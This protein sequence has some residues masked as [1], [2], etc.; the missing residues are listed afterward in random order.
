MIIYKRTFSI[1]KGKDGEAH[2][3]LVEVVD[4]INV[5]YPGHDA[6]V[7]VNVHGPVNQLHF[8]ESFASLAEMEAVFRQADDDPA[9]LALAARG[10][11][12]LESDEVTIYR[13]VSR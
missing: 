10:Q 7:L 2:A 12:L 6:H 5:H 4:W 11:G 3:Y 9:W 1:C 8:I 13:R